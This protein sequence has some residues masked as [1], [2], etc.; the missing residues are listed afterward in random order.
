[1]P[2]KPDKHKVV[3]AFN[4]REALLPH[5]TRYVDFS[6]VRGSSRLLARMAETIRLA[7]DHTCQLISGHTGCGKTTELWRLK[8]RLQ[9]GEPRFFTLLFDIDNI[10][11]PADVDAADIL[12]AVAKQVYTEAAKA[13]PNN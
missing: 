2:T 8:D 10:I 13:T 7:D 11:D 5:D 1:M 4:P 6:V 3:R 12:L 9:S